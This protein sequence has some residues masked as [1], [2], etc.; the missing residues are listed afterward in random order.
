MP[1]KQA[2]YG[3]VLLTAAGTQMPKYID[4]RRQCVSCR[5]PVAERTDALNS[6]TSLGSQDISLIN[7]HN[8]VQDQVVNRKLCACWVPNNLAENNK[9]HHMGLSCI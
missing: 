3:A 6:L 9:A 5:L 1:W 4:H 8:I 7:A 2:L